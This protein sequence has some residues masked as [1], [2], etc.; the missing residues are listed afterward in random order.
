MSQISL[1]PDAVD[2]VLSDFFKSKVPQQWSGPPVAAEPSALTATRT[3]PAVA[4]HGARAR[5]TLAASVALLLGAFW[6][7]SGGPVPSERMHSKPPAGQ[8]VK[9]DDGTAT[10]PPELQKSRDKNAKTTDDPMK[11]FQAPPPIAFP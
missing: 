3:A 11:G 1:E 8:G 10:M 5:Y 2:K 4:D 6:Y 7:L 9:I